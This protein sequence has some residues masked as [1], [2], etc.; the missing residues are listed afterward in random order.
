MNTET[1]EES[2][3]PLSSASVAEGAATASHSLPFVSV[4]VATRNEEEHIGELLDSLVEQTYPKNGFEVIVVDGLSKD[5]T[6]KV[7]EQYKE[8]LNIRAFENPRIRS[9]YAF[10]KG[11]D[12]AKGELLMMVSAHGVLSPSFMERDVNT[13]LRVRRQEPKLAGVGCVL[14]NKSENFFSK[15]VGLIYSSFFSGARMSRYAKK[16]HFCDTVIFGLFDKSI[17]VSNGKFDEDF[18]SAG[19]DD[20]LPLR[21][22]S[23]G[24]K[25]YTDPKVVAY[26]S[27]RG[28]FRGF[29]KQTFNY[30]VAKGLLVRKGYNNIEL[31][32]PASYWF[33]P[34][35]LLL[36]EM[37]LLFILGF[38]RSYFL[39]ALIPFLLYWLVDVS[40]SLHLL[41]RTKS[42]LCIALPAMYFVLHNVLGLSSLM[43]LVLG[44]RAFS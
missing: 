27:T 19:E 25:V 38:Y 17:V 34:A 2:N 43:G 24:F 41:I 35:S 42:R 37:L 30:G 5:R 3:L 23:R 7:V 11:L 18:A 15:I 22:I 6:L 44:K 29:L 26:Y 16:P 20:E 13:F 36:Y 21:L 40:V 10:N 4:V 31:Y 39:F 33:I 14:E 9:V 12:E 8:C 28:S 32:N 1:P